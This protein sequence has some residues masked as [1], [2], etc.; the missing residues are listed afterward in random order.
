MAPL[1]CIRTAAVIGGVG[2]IIP[3]NCRSSIVRESKPTNEVLSTARP[4]FSPNIRSTVAYIR[5]FQ[6]IPGE[7]GHNATFARPVNFAMRVYR[8]RKR[9]LY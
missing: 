5:R 4:P 3:M 9:S 2:R 8:L 6:A 7:G 1:H